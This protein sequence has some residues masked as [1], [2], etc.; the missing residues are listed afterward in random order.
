MKKIRLTITIATIVLLVLMVAGVTL[1]IVNQHLSFLDTLY[2]AIAFS[3]GI[4][5]MLM[6]VVSQIDAY[7]QEHI[8]AQLKKE[9]NEINRE[10]DE[11]LRNENS[12]K[13]QLNRIEEDVTEKP[14]KSKQ[15]V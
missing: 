10:S 2:E 13:R 11:Q 4:A 5:G 12:I 3:I 9:L 14:R 7:R 8:I 1:L 15:K 6:S